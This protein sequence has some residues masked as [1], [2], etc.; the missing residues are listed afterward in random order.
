[1]ATNQERISQALSFILNNGSE[2]FPVQMKRRDTGAIAYRISRGGA[3]GNT[4]ESVQEVDEAT[5]IRKVLDLGCAVRC[6][7]HD[8]ATKGL[9]KP[10][11]RSVREVRRKAT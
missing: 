7:S 3:G 9:Y 5:M 2:V 1:M 11:Q 6:T 8:G 10:G 4:L